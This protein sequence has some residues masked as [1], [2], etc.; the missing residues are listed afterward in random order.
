[1]T[2]KNSSFGNIRR[3]TMLKLMGLTFALVSF[4]M[5]CRRRQPIRMF[6]RKEIE[7]TVEGW[8]P[9]ESLFFKTAYPGE[10]GAIGLS[11]ETHEG[12]PT[13][14]EGNKVHFSSMG[15][16]GIHE[17]ASL[18]EL[19][20]EK[21]SKV[22]IKKIKGVSERAKTTWTEWMRFQEEH[23]S[24]LKDV[25]GEGLCFLFGPEDSITKGR[26]IKLL[27]R[28]YPKALFFK[29]DPLYL[30][31]EEQ[32]LNLV[33]GKEKLRLI[34]DL[35]K[36][37]IILSIQADPF[38]QAPLS[39]KN[40]YDYS[41]L[42]KAQL[43][44]GRHLSRL[45]CVEAKYS[46]TASIA[47]HRISLSIADSISFLKILSW[48]IFPE[49]K[50]ERDQLTELDAYRDFISGLSRDLKENMKESL[51]IIGELMPPEA[52]AMVAVL[53][54]KLGGRG[55]TY[56]ILD[57]GEASLAEKV[58]A[59]EVIVDKNCKKLEESIKKGRVKTLVVVNSNPIYLT[60]KKTNLQGLFQQVN[61]IICAGIYEDETA[62]LSDWHLPLSHYLEDWGDTRD[63]SGL[64]LIRQPVLQE[65]LYDTRSEYEFLYK[66]LEA[67]NNKAFFPHGSEKALDLVLETYLQENTSDSFDIALIRG[68][69]GR[70]F[71]VYLEKMKNSNFFL[72]SLDNKKS[73][74][75]ILEWDY[76]VLD[77]RFSNINWLQELEDP[78][79]KVTWGNVALI[80]KSLAV[81][82]GIENIRS[83]VSTRVDVVSIV[84]EGNNIEIPALIMPGVA[85]NSIIV[86]IGYGRGAA[87]SSLVIGEN[88]YKIMSSTGGRVLY[89]IQLLK[90]GRVEELAITDKYFA[91]N[92][93]K[94]KEDDVLIL[95]NYKPVLWEDFDN[96]KNKEHTS[97]H[98][99]S[100]YNKWPY[101]G[102]NK[103][104]MVI[105]LNSCIGCQSC[106]ISCR[107]ENNIPIVGKDQIK[108]RRD[109]SWLRVD[110]YFVGDVKNPLSFSQPVPCMHCEQAPCEPSC[111]TSA[112]VHTPEGL[113]T[114]IYNRCSGTRF[115]A[116][117][118]PYKVRKFN[119]FD[120][121]QSADVFP[122]IGE[123]KVQSL[124]KMQRN[125]E[126]SVRY[127]GVMEKCTYCVQ[128]IVKG[129]NRATQMG[130]DSNFMQDETLKIEPA[131][132][133]VCPTRAISFGNL[134]D[135][136][137]EVALDKGDQRNYEPLIGKNLS[138]RTTYLYRV[139][140]R[141]HLVKEIKNDG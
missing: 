83:L 4:N 52:H 82:Y 96:V 25:K 36:A 64:V 87:D 98:S 54:E 139:L 59:E 70:E 9:G 71:P 38:M 89:D 86:P 119:Y 103:W 49:L 44:E 127:R 76:K 60:S 94:I 65:S 42:R 132:A 128:R 126:V 118:C 113:N 57:A 140:N 102:G 73:V 32:G 110:R 13:K 69:W 88:A 78:I 3:R 2:D 109:M 31:N 35:R 18:L 23:F 90:T 72:K 43:K 112:V 40:A 130:F 100:L 134:N 50:N 1:M 111:P 92:A 55:H 138:P 85:Q 34:Y 141:S 19:Y 6:P 124:S 56:R 62:A 81:E 91:E 61:T 115:C 123:E 29:H 97:K 116:A 84:S 45:Y 121:S 104:G 51:I 117:S 95:K 68:F 63:Y 107:A 39:L 5:G 47:D 53:N 46:V 16:V 135:L 17:Q 131:C 125:P 28:E 33:Y 14:I 27:A 79:T 8:T 22:P 26:L 80:S 133:Q 74:E 10:W 93:D 101:E 11:V 66:I 58:N 20:D 99:K 15:T 77:G 41:L 136:K 24:C 12:R 114:M 48:E 137:S 75:V 21:R 37:K 120:Y 122:D 67:G 7:G 106:V 30:F 108:A 105:D 129:K